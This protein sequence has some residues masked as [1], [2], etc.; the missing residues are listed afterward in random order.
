[1]LFSDDYAQQFATLVDV[2]TRQALD[3]RVAANN[4]YFWTGVQGSI[5]SA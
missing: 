1:M 5:C 2:A 4:E 3:E